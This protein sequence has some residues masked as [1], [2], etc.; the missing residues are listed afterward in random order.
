MRSEVFFLL[1]TMGTAVFW[2][3]CENTGT[4]TRL[5]ASGS[6]QVVRLTEKEIAQQE[7]IAQ[8]ARREFCC[9]RYDQ[10]ATILEPL[11]LQQT[12]SQPLYQC[13]LGFCHLACNHKE[14]AKEYL[15]NAYTSIEGFFDPTSEKKAVSL[16]GAETQKVFKGEPYEQATLSLFVGMLLL[17]EGDVDNALACFKNGEIA[18][19]DV[20]EDRYKCDYGLLQFMEAKCYQ[21][22]GETE[23]AAQ[24]IN[25]AIISF[26]KTHP[27]VLAS[28]SE[29]ITSSPDNPLSEEEK[30]EILREKMKKVEE[31]VCSEYQSYYAPLLN[32][33]NTLLLI[34]TGRCPTLA[35]GGQYGEDRVFLKNQ[36][37]E[38]HYEVL[39]DGSAWHDPIRG[40]ADIT[41]QATTRGGRQ[42]D[43]VLA[44]QAAFKQSTQQ[45]GKSMFDMAN[46]TSD[47]Y[48]KLAFL[49]TGLIATGISN[50]ANVQAD[51][52]GVQEL[53]GQFGVI[54]LQLPPGIHS[55]R[56]DCYDQNF[57]LNRSLSHEFSLAAKPFQ[58]FN[59]VI[60]SEEP[61]PPAPTEQA[62]TIANS[63]QS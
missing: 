39:V 53:P 30:A 1:I 52:R 24:F 29:E 12:V 51:I 61:P 57:K 22:R 20:S 23:Y 16:W 26:T 63:T 60:P 34:W 62:E 10:A 5:T 21:L 13:E 35:R 17:E 45:F 2:A 27:C 15:M 58:F 36:S 25:N 59:I 48:A 50:A 19:S 6:P 44:D 41:F 43:N 47:S 11:C 56:V 4:S 46:N 49:V 54:P 14:K 33:H 38:T 37:P 55:I 28:E 18:D 8:Q 7:Q 9:G 42:M 32:P 3:G 31:F 40:Y